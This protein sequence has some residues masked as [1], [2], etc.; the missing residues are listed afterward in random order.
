M[1]RK[2][3]FVL[4]P[5][6]SHGAWAWQP[7]AVRLRAAGHPA[8]ALTMPGLGYGDDPT[9]VTLDDAVSHIAAEIRGRDLVDVVLVSHSWGG[10]PATGA[11]HEVAP[12]ISKVVYVSAVV[13]AAGVSMLDESP[14]PVAGFMREAIA[15]APDGTVPVPFEAFA[16][17]MM[18]GEPER[19]QRLVHDLLTPHPG[20]YLLDALAVAPVTTIGLSAAYLLAEDDLALVKPGAEFARRLGLEPVSVPGTHEALLTHPEELAAALLRL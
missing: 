5:G 6:A 9:A 4:V 20:R 13:P 15:A 11:A 12:R 16:Q 10:V 1:T 19:L 7:V 2:S 14:P 3:A 18:Q 17:L 8:I